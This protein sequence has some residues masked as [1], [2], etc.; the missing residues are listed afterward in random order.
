MSVDSISQ[1]Q[2]GRPAGYFEES[3]VH[4]AAHVMQYQPSLSG[5]GGRWRKHQTVCALLHDEWRCSYKVHHIAY[6][7]QRYMSVWCMCLTVL[8]IDLIGTR[9]WS[10]A[11]GR[12]GW[13]QLKL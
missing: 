6:D 8:V 11:T 10:E 9:T 7:E 2:L 1:A 12:T 3:G 13:R 4:G 5:S